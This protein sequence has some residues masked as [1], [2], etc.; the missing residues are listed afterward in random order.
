MQSEFE[1]TAE[2]AQ[3][4][5]VSSF[6]GKELAREAQGTRL[7]TFPKE[8]AAEARETSLEGLRNHAWGPSPRNPTLQEKKSSYQ[9]FVK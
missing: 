6:L 7:R 5:F 1:L 8:P 3:K 9:V 2:S 4:K